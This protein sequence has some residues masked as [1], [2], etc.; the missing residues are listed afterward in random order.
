MFK[1]STFYRI[2]KKRFNL[3]LGF[4]LVVLL[5]NG[6]V[7][8]NPT[9]AGGQTAKVEG[10]VVESSGLAKESGSEIGVNEAA[11]TLSRIN[12]DGSTVTVSLFEVKTDKDGIFTVETDV[13]GES[14]L[15]VVAVK[16]N[17]KWKAVV[18]SE[19]K[20]GITVY[21][22][23]LT[24]E[25]TTE[26]EIFIKSR[27]NG[28][29]VSYPDIANY[30]SVKAASEISGNN[31][32]VDNIITAFENEESAKSKAIINSAIG[33]T[34]EEWENIKNLKLAAQALLERDLYFA[35]T[36]SAKQTA[37]EKYFQ[38][39]VTAYINTGLSAEV[40]CKVFEISYRSYIKAIAEFNSEI[41]F[42]LIK[43]ISEIRARAINY[44]MQMKMSELDVDQSQMNLTA[45]TGLNLINSVKNS[46]DFSDIKNSFDEYHSKILGQLKNSLGIYGSI[47]LTLDGNVLL[48]QANLEASVESANSIDD[49]LN[50]YFSF[51]TKVKNEVKM[52]I[53]NGNQVQV[54]IAIQF[55]TLLNMIY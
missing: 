49:L 18:S 15:V 7:K 9:E 26:A 6:C 44:A 46:A 53:T 37:F 11:V 13:D 47:I 14:N 28:L 19:V 55:L 17:K 2:N 35:E 48:L 4:V 21:S 23:P 16:D 20:T 31:N 30:I 51:F 40:F 43:K 52:N 12:N 36:E 3:L 41:K 34:S 10:R 39:V 38:A 25:T 54:N 29:K 8:E 42:E 27:T 32:L 50:A 33:G 24:E 45:S 5:L 22:Q 1:F